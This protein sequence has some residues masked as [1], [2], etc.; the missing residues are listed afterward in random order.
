MSSLKKPRPGTCPKL[1][2]SR[3]GSRHRLT[4]RGSRGRSARHPTAA[5]TAISAPMTKRVTSTAAPPHRRNNGRRR[6]LYRSRRSRTP[7]PRARWRH[8]SGAPP[9]R[10]RTREDLI[11]SLRRRHCFTATTGHRNLD[12]LGPKLHRAVEKHRSHSH[13]T[14]E[15]PSDADR[16]GVLAG[17]S[18]RGLTPTGAHGDATA[19]F[20]PLPNCST[21][22]GARGASERRR[23][24]SSKKTSCEE[25]VAICHAEAL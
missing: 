1:H 12:I 20:S 23:E 14:P 10:G 8:R 17:G 15:R 9:R 22:S 3:I 13:P 4:P 2:I 16:I 5:P 24:G 25:T 21:R 18:T 19:S 11:P 7:P 6:H